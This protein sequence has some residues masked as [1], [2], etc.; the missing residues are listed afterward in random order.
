MLASLRFRILLAVAIALLS[1]SLIGA[2]LARNSAERLAQ[3]LQ[4]QNLRAMAFGF[5]SSVTASRSWVTPRSLRVHSGGCGSVLLPTARPRFLYSGYNFVQV[6]VEDDAKPGV[7]YFAT[8]VDG[9]GET[10]RGI[11]LRA[12]LEQPEEPGWVTL[13][14][15]QSTR[16]M[17]R[18]VAEQMQSYFL[19]AGLISIGSLLSAVL[20]LSTIFRPLSRLTWSVERRSSE[21][22]SPIQ[23][24]VPVEVR[25]LKNRL[26][27]L[28]E[29]VQTEQE[30]VSAGLERGPPAAHTADDDSTALRPRPECRRPQRP[31]TALDPGGEAGRDARL[32]AGAP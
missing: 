25:P 14:V 26:N 1:A 32:A 27:A 30:A 4:D 31:S 19:T 20:I 2:I 17:Q 11:S 13:Q 29:Q 6:P 3:N 5:F 28:L 22:L 8:W 7:P 23:Q 21:D 12:F 24:P 15:A 18:L 16:G 10:Y 9:S